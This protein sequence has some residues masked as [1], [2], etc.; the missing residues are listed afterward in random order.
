MLP[1]TVALATSKELLSALVKPMELAVSWLP[2]PATLSR[3]PEKATV[4]LPA[5]V[6]MSREAVPRSEPEPELTVRLTILLAP[7]PTVESLPKDLELE[8]SFSYWKRTVRQEGQ[9]L[10]ISEFSHLKTARLP[11]DKTPEIRGYYEEAIARKN[12]LVVLK[13]K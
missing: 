10:V 3:R 9:R 11:K 7:R 8:N 5:A 4:P 1:V 12:E 6:P 13:G 2:V